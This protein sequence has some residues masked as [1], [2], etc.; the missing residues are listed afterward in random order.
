MIGIAD[1][2]DLPLISA[3]TPAPATGSRRSACRSTSGSG[4]RPI[5]FFEFV[6]LESPPAASSPTAAPCRRSAAPRGPRGD[7]R[8]TT[9]RPET[10]ECGSNVL[11]GTTDPGRLVQCVEV[12]VGSST[13]WVSPYEG[14]RPSSR[15][16]PG[17]ET[18]S[19]ARSPRADRGRSGQVA[20][21]QQ[22]VHER[23][24]GTE[25]RHERG[26]PGTV[27]LSHHDHTE[28]AGLKV[29]G[30]PPWTG[31]AGIPRRPGRWRRTPPVGRSRGG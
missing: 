5:G 19:P 21:G 3:S 12:M 6:K 9:E 31:G 16:R 14:P 10:V 2:L 1:E 4:S 27:E 8:D 17:A 29:P 15:R 28:P 25:R 22:R 26:I 20:E 11:S 30:L 18:S 24:V 23:R 13:D 7:V